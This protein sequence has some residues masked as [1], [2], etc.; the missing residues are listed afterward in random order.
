MWSDHPQDLVGQKEITLNSTGGHTDPK[1][2]NAGMFL[3]EKMPSCH[4]SG[5]QKLWALMLAGGQHWDWGSRLSYCHPGFKGSFC[6]DSEDKQ[7]HTGW[8]SEEILQ[9]PKID[10][11]FPHIALGPKSLFVEAARA[12]FVVQIRPNP[13]PIS[14]HERCVCRARPTPHTL[15]SQTLFS[16]TF[17]VV[18][19]SKLCKFRL[20]DKIRYIICWKPDK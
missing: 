14:L 3:R 18:L 10:K 4:S 20:K 13:G 2:E 9:V 17:R 19:F 15:T 8:D 16:E 11:L 5:M 7:K 1:G 12:A 6:W